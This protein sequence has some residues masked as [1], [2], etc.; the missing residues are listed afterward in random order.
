MSSRWH[1][2]FTGRELLAQHDAVMWNDSTQHIEITYP[3]NVNSKL[4]FHKVASFHQ[5]YS[6]YTLQTYQHQEHKFRSWPTQMPSPSHLHARVQPRNTYKHTY[7]KFCL[8]KTKQYYTKSRQTTC[9]LFTPDPTEYKGNLKIN[10]SALR[11]I[12]HQMVLDPMLDPNLTYS[13]R[14][15]NISLQALKPLQMIK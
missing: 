10:N 13:T 11:I 2:I 15:H 7:I 3:N 1:T 6:T 8:D 4:A 5:H 9:T 14:I 12:T